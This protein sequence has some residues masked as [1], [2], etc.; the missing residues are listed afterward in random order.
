MLPHIEGRFL[1]EAPEVAEAIIAEGLKEGAKA[2]TINRKLAIL[3]RV[4]RLAFRKW[5][6]LERDVAGRIV[7]LPGEEPRSAKATP[8]QA[9]TL[10]LAA[11]PR[12]RQAVLWASLTGLRKGELQRVQPHHFEGRAIV[13]TRTKGNKPRI[14]PLAPGLSAKD[15]P[16]HLTERELTTDYR[17]AR[18]AAGLD[19]LQFRDL[20]R[21]FGSW[22]VQKT[23]STKV[24]Q[25]LL[26]HTT[27]V[28]TDRHYAHLLTGNLSAAVKMLPRL[29]GLARGKKKAA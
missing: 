5:Q 3:R 27:P 14:V 21:T 9:R 1:D 7:L 8:Q 10:L 11:K 24:A 20:R 22:I 6:W 18:R 19:W 28:I 2:G 23:Q 13:L 17:E 25:D 12:T 26:G 15:F 4:S 16:F 29:A